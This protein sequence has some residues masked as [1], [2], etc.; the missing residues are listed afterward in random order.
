MLITFLIFFLL[1]ISLIYS[2]QTIDYGCEFNST[3]YRVRDDSR[4]CI[5][6]RFWWISTED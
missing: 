3:T 4:L 1:N 6:F 5:F 2:K